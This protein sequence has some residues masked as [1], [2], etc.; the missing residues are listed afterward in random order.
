M[1]FCFFRLVMIPRFGRVKF[2]KSINL[3]NVYWGEKRFWGSLA[4]WIKIWMKLGVFCC[5]FNVIVLCLHVWGEKLKKMS[6]FFMILRDFQTV[7]IGWPFWALLDNSLISRT[8]DL[9]QDTKKWK[10]FHSSVKCLWV[11]DF[12]V[13]AIGFVRP[14]FSDH[15]PLLHTRQKSSQTLSSGQSQQQ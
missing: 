7:N 13:K 15:A 11:C 1:I 6:R 14:F 2:R 5:F 9:V 8:Q 12:F 4:L 3:K 10:G